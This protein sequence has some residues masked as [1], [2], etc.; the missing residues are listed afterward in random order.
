MVDIEK[1]IC[2]RSLRT[3]KTRGPEWTRCNND[4]LVLCRRNACSNRQINIHLE[5]KLQL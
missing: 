2:V 4:C 1:E 3:F 5:M